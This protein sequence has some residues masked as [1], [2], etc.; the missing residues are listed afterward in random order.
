MSGLVKHH[1]LRS[2]LFYLFTGQGGQGLTLEPMPTLNSLYNLT[3][4]LLLGVV[5]EYNPIGQSQFGVHSQ[6]PI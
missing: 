4:T 2:N 3:L 6:N 1:Y 5:G